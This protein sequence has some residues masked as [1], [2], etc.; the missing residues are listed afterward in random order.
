VALDRYY[1]LYNSASGY[2]ELMFHAGDGL[3]S[4]ELNEVQTWLADRLARIGDAIFKEGD[5]IRDGDVSVDP[6]TGEVNLASGIVYLRGAARP[7]GAATFVIPVDRTV[8]LGVRFVETI[9]TELEDPALRDPAVGTRNYQEPGAAR[10]KE[11]ILWGWDSGNQNDGGTGAFH[12]IYTVTNGTL[13]SRIQPPELD[14]VLQTV[15]RYDREANGSYVATGLELTYLTR[16]DAAAEYVFSLAEG[17][18]NVGGLKVE[19]PQST[20]LRWTVDPDLRAVNAEPHGFADGGTGTA[21]IPVNL[22]PIAEVTDVTITRETPETVTHGAFTGASDPLANSTVVAVLSVSQGGTA[23]TQGVDY[24]VS[25]G[26]IDWSPGGAEPAPGSSYSV[27]YRYIDSIAPDAVTDEAVTV[28]GAVT[29]TTVFIDYAYKLPRIDAL[30]MSAGGQLSR[31][32][33]V[34]QTLN[35]QPPQLPGSVLPLAEV[36]L[37]WFADRVP[38][39]RN[40]ATR[41]VPFADLAAM[42]R[43]ISSL[44]QLVAI[45]RLRN[46]ANITDPTSKLGV[47]VDPF[48]DDDL[49]DQGIPQSAAVLWGE[50]TLPIT[51]AVQEPPEGASATWTLAYELTPVLEQLASTR[52]MKI[53]PYMNFEPVPAAVTLVP[54]VDNWTTV[55]TQWTSAITRAFTSGSGRL[56]RTSVSTSTELVSSTSRAALDIRQRSVGFTLRGMDPNEALLRVEFDGLDVTPDPAP[57]ADAAGVLSSS[58]QIPSGVPTGSKSVTF[59]G[60]AGSFGE[61]TYTANGTI[62]TNTFRSV[63]TRRTVRWSPPPPPPPPRPPRAWDPLAQTIVLDT[64]TV[65]A[66]L[67]IWFDAIGRADAPTIVQIR[68]T[69]VGF[70]ND[71]VVTSSEVD[72]ATVTLDGPTRVAFDPTLLRAGREYALVFLTDDPDHALRVA[73]LGKYDAE[74]ETWVTAQPYRIGVL[75]SSSNASTWTPHQERDLKFRLLAARFTETT[76]TVAL[77]E[78]TVSESTDFIALAGVERMSSETDVTFVLRDSGGQVFRMTEGAALNLASRVSDRLSVEA[79]LS[80]SERFTP[81]LFPGVQVL[82]GALASEAE[83]VSR[84]IPAA[85]T[86]DVSVY[87]DTLIPPG[88]GVAVFAETDAGWS[89]LTLESGQPIKNGGEER[90]YV[91]AGLA[92]VGAANVTRIKIALSGTPA[93]RP[94]VS[95]LRAILK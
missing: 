33:G 81:V 25:A 83:Y 9:V 72:M 64:D 52:A 37:D 14:A 10:R 75:L 50:L 47:F 26:R 1:N 48:L 38:L 91:G 19:R 11:Q 6:I 4:R 60:E 42:Q 29:G 21:V 67:D 69:T 32:R 65:V 57:V 46:D 22:A 89:A 66:G 79:V 7:V 77:G 53:N 16:D 13:D 43:Q 84:A 12:A 95:A 44:F 58:F 34:S 3:Q 93:A 85:A 28:S 20:R 62:I 41:A 90:H 17:V 51:A 86:F 30:V 78:I 2:A 36:A 61:S 54:S 63:T 5:L 59:L 35:P 27:T 87:L 23:Y 73:E 76:R 70:P 15:A 24:V 68:E 45:E 82:N 92:G 94:F 39:V 31:V 88:A 74:T 8:A 18:G 56:S 80:G 49:R 40:T 71:T 55:E